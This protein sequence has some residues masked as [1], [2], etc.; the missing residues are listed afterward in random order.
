MVGTDQI[1]GF[2]VVAFSRYSDTRHFT[3]RLVVEVMNVD[4]HL[5]TEEDAN[6]RKDVISKANQPLPQ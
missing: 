2:Q 6:S 1:S 5:S 3:D 4:L